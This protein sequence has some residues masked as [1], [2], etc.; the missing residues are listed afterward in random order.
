MQDRKK[1]AAAVILSDSLD[2][3]GL[4]GVVVEVDPDTADQLGVFHEDAID[5][6]TAWEANAD[7]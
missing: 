6:E 4:P 2:D 1:S 5:E 3:V 7:L